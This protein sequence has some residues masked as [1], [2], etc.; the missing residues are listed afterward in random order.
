MTKQEFI[1]QIAQA[2][3]KI[4][5]EFGIVVYSP[6][7]AQACLESAYGTS[8]KAKY[9]NFFGLKY[10]EGRLTCHSGTF[11]DGSSE[12]LPDG[13]YVPITDQWYSFSSL[14]EGVRGYFQFTNIARYSNLKGV[15]D[16]K[17]YLEL[18]KEDGYA[19]SQKYVENV[20]N[21]LV[22]NNLTKYDKEEKVMPTVCI[23]AGHYG[24]YNR[25][26]AV[27]EYYESDMNWKLS[28]LQGKYLNQ[29]GVSVKYTRADKNKDLE[30]YDRGMASKGCD[31]FISNHSNATTAV[32]EDIDYV[33][34]YN[35]VNDT[36]TNIDEISKKYAEAL[37][38]IIAKLMGT[39][40]GYRVLTR[41]SDNDRNKD[42][43]MNDNYYGVLNG[44][45]IANTPG[46]IIEH[47]FHTNTAA[48][49]WLLNDANLDKMA[50]AEAECIASILLG[51]KVT[52]GV[53]EEPK[54]EEP[55]QET[56]PSTAKTLYY[57]QS[58]AFTIQSNAEK[59]YI[60]LKDKGFDAIIK[61]SGMYFKVQV[62]AYSDKNNATSQ[63]A[64]VKKAGFEAYVTTEGGNAI[65]IDVKPV[66]PTVPKKTV[67][68]LALEVIQGKWGN[69]QARIDALTKAGYN[70]KDVQSKVDEMLGKNK[71]VTKTV[72]Q[73]AREVWAGKWG[74]GAE[75]KKK[76]TEAGY[77]Y[78]AVQAMVNKLYR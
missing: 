30:L 58:G 76:L 57:V 45:R 78:D 38:P 9:N 6:I 8:N 34:V 49:K 52:L 62:G 10:R 29:L 36:T 51:K 64:K 32:K 21:T 55:K 20:Y 54:K 5:P 35:L 66:Q 72:E 41:Q 28:Q 27:P 39:K 46:L 63:A 69:G 59:R 24:K 61:K 44:A 13:S 70:S 50:R 71:P 15:S 12:Q 33:A 48:T 26:P 14:K 7:I 31:L 47:S 73:L 16:P 1:E 18:I 74:N 25:S 67:E 40:Q 75:R 23:D 19:T 65:T 53:S 17:K 4:A 56:K 42:G 77:D 68:E 22:T 60:E 37:A 2:V 3:K 11:V 43:I